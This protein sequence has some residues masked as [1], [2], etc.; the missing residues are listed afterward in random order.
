MS[1][2]AWPTVVRICPLTV[3]KICQHVYLTQGEQKPTIFTK[4]RIFPT[5]QDLVPVVA[6]TTKTF[7]LSCHQISEVRNINKR[8]WLH[9]VFLNRLLF[10]YNTNQCH[11]QATPKR[12]SLTLLRWADLFLQLILFCELKQ[13]LLHNL[14]LL[15]LFLLVNISWRNKPYRYI[16]QPAVQGALCHYGFRKEFLSKWIIIKT[17]L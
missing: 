7:C 6:Q 10:F 1:S 8:C 15:F 13:K 5:G 9:R 14:L 16:K 12:G 3:N 17:N 4:I 11:L 2:W